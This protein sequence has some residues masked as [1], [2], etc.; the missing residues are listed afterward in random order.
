MCILY[1]SMP[2]PPNCPSLLPPSLPSLSAL[3]VVGEMAVL[4]S[5]LEQLGVLSQPNQER[6]MLGCR[7]H[8][9][10]HGRLTTVLPRRRDEREG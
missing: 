5:S 4:I 10:K 6:A 2:Q 9:R 8:Y 1:T 7:R 3:L